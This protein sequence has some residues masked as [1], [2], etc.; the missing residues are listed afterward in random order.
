ML[1]SVKYHFHRPHAP[2]SIRKTLPKLCHSYF[3][4]CCV[5][6]GCHMV[7]MNVFV[8]VG[9]CVDSNH[10][11]LAHVF[12]LVF[13]FSLIVTMPHSHLKCML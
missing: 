2:L 13:L 3:F 6:C 7:T 10:Q 5:V 8:W 11:L 1:L 9:C 12:K 4:C